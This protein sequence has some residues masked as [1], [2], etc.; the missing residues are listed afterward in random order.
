MTL[1]IAFLLPG[2]LIWLFSFALFGNVHAQ[3]ASTKK[4][5][6]R[7]VLD[8]EDF[9]TGKF[10]DIT[11]DGDT[12]L[13]TRRNKTQIEKIGYLTY[14]LKIT[15]EGPCQYTLVPVSRKLQ[16]K[17]I[18]VPERIYTSIIFETGDGYY[19]CRTS[20]DGFDRTLEFTI[21]TRK[22]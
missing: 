16:G 6:A 14:T 15:W 20:V 21:F 8:C 12:I 4:S 22:D 7:P 9:R 19:K 11:A 2:S 17:K 3:S 1:K 10:L 18:D 13:I 5:T